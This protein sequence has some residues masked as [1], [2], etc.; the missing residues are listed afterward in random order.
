M[1]WAKILLSIGV[2]EMISLCFLEL[3]SVTALLFSLL[4]IFMEFA[5]L[6]V[7]ALLFAWEL[8]VSLFYYYSRNWAKIFRSSALLLLAPLFVFFN[9][10][11]ALAFLVITG[12]LLL[13]YLERFLQKGS[14]DDYVDNF[15]RVVAVYAVAFFIRWGLADIGGDVNEAAPFIFVYFLS[16]IVLIR[17]ARHIE[18]GMDIRRLQGTNIRYLIFIATAFIVASVDEVRQIAGFMVLMFIR[19]LFSPVLLLLQLFGWFL[20]ILGRW[21]TINPFWWVDLSKFLGI[22][23]FGGEVPPAEGIKETVMPA[24]LNILGKLLPAL[25]IGLG[26]FVLYRL[27]VR[28]G[29]GG[30]QGLD[31]VEE[32]EH[33]KREAR[34]RKRRFRLKDRLPRHPSEQVRYYYRR[35]LER[36]VTERVD[37]TRANTSLE[38]NEKAESVFTHGPEEIRDIYVAS[39]YGEKEVDSAAVR[40]M[41][42]LY[43]ELK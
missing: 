11:A 33:L 24:W 4:L 12:P 15:K 43:K 1:L 19:L 2:E 23:G 39:R 26:V 20:G 6:E 13:L 27:L 17:S 8:A 14:Y 42:Q 7:M 16:S 38:V 9:N 29:Q 30:Y 3:L 37:L 18:A 22:E 40:R 10:R 25:L 5:T 21:I 31:Y 35:F 28:V 41:E 34:G 32:R 36:L